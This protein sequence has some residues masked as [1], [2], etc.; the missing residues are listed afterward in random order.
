MSGYG[1]D[2]DDIHVPLVNLEP[3]KANTSAPLGAA[4]KAGKELG[5]VD[6]SPS[7]TKPKMRGARRAKSEPQ[8][9]ILITGPERVLEKLRRYSD[10]ENIPY[11]LA[12]EKLLTASD[13]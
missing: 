11:W 8:G 5:F 4:K 3:S 12:L 10:E 1:F 9:K 2:D 6:R 7:N 13:M